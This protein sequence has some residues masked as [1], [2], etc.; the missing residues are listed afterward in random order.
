MPSQELDIL[1]IQERNETANVFIVMCS[2]HEI[3]DFIVGQVLTV[4][5]HIF[6][7]VTKSE[8]GC[9]V[10]S[11]LGSDLCVPNDLNSSFFVPSHVYQIS[12]MTVSASYDGNFECHDENDEEADILDS[13]SI[14]PHH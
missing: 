11:S 3:G 1:R 6:V 12:K 2:H 10:S 5:H 9:I 8:N 4:K 14:H 7:R 13:H